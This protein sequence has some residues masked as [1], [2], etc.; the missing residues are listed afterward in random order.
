M[1]PRHI[2]GAQPV[3]STF[4]L[5]DPACTEFRRLE[6]FHRLSPADRT[7]R[8]FERL[9]RREGDLKPKLSGGPAGAK[10]CLSMLTYHLALPCMLSDV[11]TDRHTNNT[12]DQT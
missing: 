1:E 3:N 5:A 7:G 2:C 12:E 8:D 11:G 10:N 6:D 4:S 9:G